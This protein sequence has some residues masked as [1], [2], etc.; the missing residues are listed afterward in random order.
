MLLM[1]RT[2]SCPLEFIWSTRTLVTDFD[3]A[4]EIVVLYTKSPVT[5][6]QHPLSVVW[7]A[8]RIAE[9]GAANRK[10]LELLYEV[11]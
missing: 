5:Y 4:K 10:F 1:Q 3:K 2:A 9:A 11:G 7:S 6:N 8:C